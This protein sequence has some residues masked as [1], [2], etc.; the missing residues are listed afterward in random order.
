[1][2][3][4]STSCG[5]SRVGQNRMCA[6]YMTVC[7]YDDF[8]A[9]NA[10]Y[11]PY[12]LIIIWFWPTLGI[13]KRNRCSTRHCYMAWTLLYVEVKFTRFRKGLRSK[14]ATASLLIKNNRFMQKKIICCCSGARS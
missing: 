11:T 7:M 4:N 14:L 3:L 1:M 9:N 10:V 2:R 5:I 12:K 13:S 8:P 6:P